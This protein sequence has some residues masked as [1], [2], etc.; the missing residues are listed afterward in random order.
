MKIFVI[1]LS[2]LSLFIISVNVELSAKLPERKIITSEINN[3]QVNIL[4]NTIYVRFKP[5]FNLNTDLEEFLVSAGVE[6][7]HKLLAEKFSLTHNN[8]LQ[9][10]FHSDK[11]RTAKILAAEEPLLRTFRF[12]Y[13][14]IEK[15]LSFCK[16]LINKFPEIEI[17]E[18]VY[19]AKILYMPND[20]EAPFQGMLERIQA[21]D[22][23][24]IYKG[25]SSVVI[26]IS[27]NGVFQQHEDLI[28]NIAPNYG[29]IPKNKGLIR[30]KISHL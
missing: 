16:G 25:D 29:E 8:N 17:A 20:P 5:G 14:G 1:F 7:E 2:V 22:A 4:S 24:D 15:P 11:L 27:D 28:D 23:W 12:T 3:K 13:E 10:S 6:I 21:F 18:P 30:I 19:A 9:L 26:G